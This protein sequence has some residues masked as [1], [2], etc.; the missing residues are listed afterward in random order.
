MSDSSEE[1]T[2]EPEADDPPA[3]PHRPGSHLRPGEQSAWER[4]EL[5]AM[6]SGHVVSRGGR[7]PSVE[8]AEVEVQPLTLEDL[9]EIREAARKEGFAEGR[10]AGLAEGHREGL[11]AGAAEVRA[12]AESLRAAVRALARPLEEQ[13]EELDEAITSLVAE[14]ARNVVRAELQARPEQIRTI[15]E[16]ALAALGEFS[17]DLQLRLHPDDLQ[18]LQGHLGDWTAEC[19][20]VADEG[21][22][23]GGVRLERGLSS[24]DYTLDKRF[25]AAVEGFVRDAYLHPVTETVAVADSTAPADPLAM[26]PVAAE[27]AKEMATEKAP[28]E[29]APMDE[30]SGDATPT[31][32]LP[33]GAAPVDEKPVDDNA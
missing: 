11:A 22:V 6:E 29:E 26:D 15:T 7:A 32:E 18:L 30:L 3:V 13:G 19:R 2:A 20:L 23:R 17:G 16:H 24:I 5:P 21:L 8:E 28:T 10:E 14:V 4:W 9:E 25:R 27:S 12:Q 31:D 33:A 1:I